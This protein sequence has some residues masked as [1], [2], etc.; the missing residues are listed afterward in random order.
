MKYQNTKFKDLKIY[1]GIKFDDTRGYFREIFKEKLLKKKLIFW[2]MSKSKKNVLRG[3]HLQTKKPQDKFVSVVKGK[4]LDVVIDCRKR[5]KTYGKYFKIILSDKN[6]KSLYIPAG[7]AHGFL[8]LA[9]E[10]LVFYGC[11]SYR[12]AKHE[13]AIKWNDKNVNINWPKSKKIISKKDLNGISIK[14]LKNL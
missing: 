1:Q 11:S 8:T 2:C 5:S 7:F 14:L 3:M 10:N 13:V 12:S 4:I 9:K 6:C